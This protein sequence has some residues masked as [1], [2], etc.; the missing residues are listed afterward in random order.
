MALSPA[1]KFA[2]EAAKEITIAKLSTSAPNT[3]DRQV[4]V[5]IGEMYEAIYK[6]IYELR[7]AAESE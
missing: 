4:G 6:K 1:Q 3:S 7:T 5:A 2:L